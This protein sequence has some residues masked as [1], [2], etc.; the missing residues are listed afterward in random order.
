MLLFLLWGMTM[1][2]PPPNAVPAYLTEVEAELLDNLECEGENLTEI[3]E[4]LH[5]GHAFPA[6][7]QSVSYL[8][9]MEGALGLLP[10]VPAGDLSAKLFYLYPNLSFPPKP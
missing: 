5:P 10:G 2:N 6:Y 4:S 8:D 7:E 3:M 1:P 9:L